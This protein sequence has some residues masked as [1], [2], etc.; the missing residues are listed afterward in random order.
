MDISVHDYVHSGPLNEPPSQLVSLADRP[1]CLSAVND[2]FKVPK[3][4]IRIIMDGTE[5]GWAGLERRNGDNT[6]DYGLMQVNTVNLQTIES[7]LGLSKELL[8]DDDCASLIAGTYL[9]R[10]HLD[11]N[12]ERLENAEG[13][14]FFDVLFDVIATYH[15][16]TPHI[17]EAYRN[18]FLEHLV[19]GTGFEQ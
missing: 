13:M 18:R 15:S 9:L 8:R 5:A 3:W 14:E 16:G 12:Q 1:N 2:Y 4:I 19:S 10:Q 17:R 6:F 11:R 7:E